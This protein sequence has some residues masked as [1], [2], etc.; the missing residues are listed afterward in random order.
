MTF[1]FL[2][3]MTVFSYTVLTFSPS[4]KEKHSIIYLIVIIFIPKGK[5]EGIMCDRWGACC[6]AAEIF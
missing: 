1:I 2:H 5:K 3:V 4:I 6:F